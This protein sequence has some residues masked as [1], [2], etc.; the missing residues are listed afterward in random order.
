[1][2]QL[3]LFPGHDPADRDTQRAIR[4]YRACRRVM[5]EV[6]EWNRNGRIGPEPRW[7][8]LAD[9]EPASIEQIG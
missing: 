2:K 9:D 6:R 5:A 4:R 3:P 8:R 1:M 7:P